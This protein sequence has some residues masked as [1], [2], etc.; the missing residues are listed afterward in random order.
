MAYNGQET[1]K[2]NVYTKSYQFYNA[3]SNV[4]P[5]TMVCTHWDNF[6]KLAINPAKP[7]NQRTQTS[8]YNYDDATT[9]AMALDRAQVLLKGIKKYICPLIYG[10]DTTRTVSSVGVQVGIN[11][12]VA[13]HY[14]D[15]EIVLMIYKN[16]DPETLKPETT[17]GYV[18]NDNVLV[19]N[20]DKD[21][22]AFDS[23]RVNSEFELFV[24]LLE[25]AIKAGTGAAAHQD[26][27]KN[28]YRK[29]SNSNRTY[30]N[31]GSL[32]DGAGNS[33]YGSNS[34]N[35]AVEQEIEYGQEITDM[36]DMGTSG[37]ID[38]D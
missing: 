29:S 19:L 33:S 18:F 32:F 5:G 25:E 30:Q 28:K 3:D 26:H 6:I 15:G 13:I 12:Q 20:Y 7:M 24:T 31:R 10:T 37:V 14:N 9:T 4:F 11:N 22:G 8:V 2:E 27:L 17:A 36:M 16:I 1:K 34:S 38:L 21:T 35:N 23:E